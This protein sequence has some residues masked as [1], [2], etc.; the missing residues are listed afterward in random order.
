MKEDAHH[1]GAGVERE[2]YVG[3]RNAQ[4]HAQGKAQ[5]DT[6]EELG[7]WIYSGHRIKHAVRTQHLQYVWACR[8]GGL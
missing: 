5:S 8:A 4:L 2:A 6:E 7:R 1:R 3:L